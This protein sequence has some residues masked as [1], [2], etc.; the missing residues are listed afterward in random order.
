MT[1]SSLEGLNLDAGHP[2]NN[3]IVTLSRSMR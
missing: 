1:Y 2:Q 3:I